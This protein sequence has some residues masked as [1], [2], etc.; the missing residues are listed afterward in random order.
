M[1]LRLALGYDS[2]QGA[3]EVTNSYAPRLDSRVQDREMSGSLEEGI[4][5]AGN[6]QVV[7]VRR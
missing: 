3:G 4:V 2:T 1:V 6:S 7:E 5:T